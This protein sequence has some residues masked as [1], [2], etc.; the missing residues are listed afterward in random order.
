MNPKETSMSSRTPARL[1]ALLALALAAGLPLAGCGGGAAGTPADDD[2]IV[3]YFNVGG[4]T[5]VYRNQ[6]LELTFSAPVDPATIGDRTIRVLT[7][8]NLATPAEGALV[9]VDGNKVIFDP[10]HSQA[11]VDRAGPD[12][13]KD[14]PFGFSA[15][16]NHQ[17]YIPGPPV[18]KTLTNL[19][20]DP[21][22]E[23]FVSSF[24]T[25]EE[26]IPE[27]VQPRFIGTDGKGALGFDPPVRPGS[28]IDPTDGPT[29][30]PF[31]ASILLVFSEPIAP[32]SMDP[33]VSVIV[34][35]MDE[36]EP[37]VGG[38][39]RVPGTL[40]PSVDGR[41]YAFVPSF[42]YG[43]G[44]YRLRVQLTQDIHDLAGNLLEQPI[45]RYFK[46]EYREGEVLT[47]TLVETFDNK[48]YMEFGPQYTTA[49]WDSVVEGRLQGGSITSTTITVV[50]EADGVASRHGGAGNPAWGPV[51]YP[52][53]SEQGNAACPSWP[54]GCRFQG[55]YTQSDIGDPGAIT[56]IYWGPSSNALFAATHPNIKIRV[57]HTKTAAGVIT[58]TFAD[59]FLGGTPNPSYD[60]LYDIP[61]RGDI[62]P[63]N[64][65]KG[66]WPFPTLTTPFEYDGVKG[67]LLDY[68]VEPAAD[69]QLL[70]YWFHG[71]PAGAGNPGSRNI[72]A[73]SATAESDTLTGGGQPLVLDMKL[74]KK[75]RTTIAQSKFYDT[76][77]AQP[78]FGAA[79]LS[80]SSQP[81][82]AEVSIEWQGATDR[83]D[84]ATYSP[85]SGQIDIAD[86]KRYIRFRMKLISNLNSNTVARLEEIRIPF[87]SR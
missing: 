83:A 66:F 77:T 32:E 13:P 14:R 39:L 57:G 19:A 40:K 80:P 70:R 85:W 53:V 24:T 28:I 20:G 72:V 23:T 74:V 65:Q 31:D 48:F 1:L 9:Q 46:T 21:I 7:G 63:L 50:Y 78:D 29:E 34:H 45:V 68:A 5:D 58:G 75:R 87:I 42:S 26:Y 12:A 36:T 64:A 15:L 52:L 11:E 82:G 18:L 25:G 60:G 3:V 17:L 79:I 41:T 35:N 76:K 49:E 81:G 33:G 71:I 59:N 61:Q 55:T 16:T 4:R 10:T 51:D 43:P 37:V 22:R 38:P 73:N 54:N 6:K 44:P 2:L 30:V 47:K 56:E 84:A 67:L 62:D 86:E 27:L 8:P 69:C